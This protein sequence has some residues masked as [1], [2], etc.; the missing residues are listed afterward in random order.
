MQGKCK[1]SFRIVVADTNVRLETTKVTVN[2]KAAEGTWTDG[3]PADGEWGTIYLYPNIMAMDMY[4]DESI[5]SYG[6]EERDDLVVATPTVD[7]LLTDKYG[8]TLT[9]SIFE[10]DDSKVASDGKLMIRFNSP[11]N[12]KKNHT[13]YL[14]VI[15]TF[16]SG[17]EVVKDKIKI[18]VADKWS[19]PSLSGEASVN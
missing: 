3:A 15:Q 2:S 13:V 11:Q 18:T 5:S 10:I 16:P 19:T 1:I 17:L 14:K 7:V 9:D 12:S 4:G 6:A 8:N